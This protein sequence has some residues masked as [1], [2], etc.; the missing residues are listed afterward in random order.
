[1]SLLFSQVQITANGETDEFLIGGIPREYDD[2]ENWSGFE[3]FMDYIQ[4]ETEVQVHAEVYLYGDGETKNASPEEIAYL[5]SRMEKDE[6][7]L[8][9]STV[10]NIESVDFSF[11]WS[12]EEL[13]DDD[14]EDEECIE[15]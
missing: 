12:P 11:I 1:M 10:D 9:R 13:F 14:P 7:F 4:E 6:Q 15:M 3:D 5:I 8:S 2:L